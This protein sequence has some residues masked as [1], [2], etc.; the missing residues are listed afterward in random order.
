MPTFTALSAGDKYTCG[1]ATGR[2]ASC[3]GAG[4]EGQL[5]TSERPGVCDDA[6]IS[7]GACARI[8]VPV[9][10]EH[11]FIAISAAEDHACAI[12]DE[13]VA[14]CWGDNNK[15]ELGVKGMLDGCSLLLSSAQLPA[16]PC[17]RTP[18]QVP[19]SVPFTSIA[20]GQ[21]GTCALDDDGR[22][23]CWG[24]TGDVTGPLEVDIGGRRLTT[25]SM[26]E[27]HACGLTAS[28]AAAC[29]DWPEVRETG[30]AAPTDTAVW[31]SIA[32]AAAHQCA[33]DLNGAAWCWGNDADG[34]LG[35]GGSDHRKFDEIARAPVAGGHRFQ[36]IAVSTTRT[37]A[38]D[39]E[40]ALYCWGYLP[41]ANQPDRCL[42][43]NG[44]SDMQHC[45]ASPVRVQAP[46]TFKSIALGESHRCAIATT[47]ITYC[48]GKND[49]GELGDGTTSTSNETVAVVGHELPAWR[50]AI[51]AAQDAKTR[52]I[53][54]NGL[55]WVLALAILVALG[56]L[57]ARWWRSGV[58]YS[59]AAGASSRTGWPATPRSAHVVGLVSIACAVAGWGMLWMTFASI[60]GN[61][62][63]DDVALG[64]AMLAVLVGGGIALVAALI[65]TVV[66]AIAL[67]RHR[68][69]PTLRIGLALSSITAIVIAGGAV[70]LFM[71]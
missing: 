16:T 64:M 11:S 45:T 24:W 38:I 5:G 34:A 49:W 15:S 29:W 43:S 3:W 30:F 14:W 9:A 18:V 17:S 55:R 6:V 36:S 27:N 57:I 62:G 33:L 71:L 42:D 44:S 26:G 63:H 47:G 67:R 61:H 19:A 56:V 25:L 1:V 58:P 35:I 59:A 68:S 66:S 2:R 20:A 7:R 70:R 54:H 46:M 4:Y 10:G 40:G 22:P 41:E 50:K 60:R 69:V 13:G 53:A 39:L 32:V 37:C 31:T 51:V 8:P 21:Y 52:F 65:G 23:W 28:G 12:D 48:W